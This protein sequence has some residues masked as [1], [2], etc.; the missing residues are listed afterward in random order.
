MEHA[1]R[2]N[3]IPTKDRIRPVFLFP[4][5]NKYMENTHLIFSLPYIYLILGE[6]S[7]AVAIFIPFPPG[8]Q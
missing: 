1:S 4:I 5:L 7:I 2:T 3:L 8:F 6:F